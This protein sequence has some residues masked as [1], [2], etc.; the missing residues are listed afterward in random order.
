MERTASA[1]WRGSLKQGNGIVSTQSHAL[2]ET[3]YSFTSRFENDIDTNPEE[4]IAAA[5]AS[6]FTMK[7]SGLLGDEGVTP[8]K[9][10]TEATLTLEE[11]QGNW[12]IT[13]I[14]L[15]LHGVVPDMENSQFKKIATEAK[16]ACPVSRVLNANITLDARLEKTLVNQL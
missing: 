8:E 1:T 3:P 16:E 10:S 12:T 6:C 15:T 7:V 9:L 4:L 13:R 11:S 5:L 14:H 2:E